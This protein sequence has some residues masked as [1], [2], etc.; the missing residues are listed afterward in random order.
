MSTNSFIGKIEKD[1]T[2]T[3]ISCYEAG[4]IEHDG[5]CLAEYYATRDK[6]DELIALGNLSVLGPTIGHKID[7]N[8]ER[9]YGAHMDKQCIAY[10]RDRNDVL[11]IH[12]NENLTELC[13]CYPYVYIYSELDN[14]LVYYDEREQM[15]YDALELYCDNDEQST[16][17][18][19]LFIFDNE[20]FLTPV[21]NLITT[22]QN[23]DTAIKNAAVYLN[24]D[25]SLFN[26]AMSGVHTDKQAIELFNKLEPRR[27]ISAYQIEKDFMLD[28]EQEVNT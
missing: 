21:E 9:E 1:G 16:L 5:K 25:I 3:G 27:I 13:E 28:E 14:W 4:D 7:F 17:K 15:L 24:K 10:H 8:N 12:T 19:Y 2:I 23:F 26:A 18:K 6:V 22:A 20:N 11:E